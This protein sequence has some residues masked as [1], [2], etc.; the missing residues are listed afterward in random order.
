[1]CIFSA[2]KVSWNAAGVEFIHWKPADIDPGS[3]IGA[4]IQN[5]TRFRVVGTKQPEG[6]YGVKIP[7]PRS[8]WCGKG[9]IQ[10]GEDA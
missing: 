2:R 10:G 4:Q 6:V 5:N 7:L 9:A 1:V 8:F 3:L